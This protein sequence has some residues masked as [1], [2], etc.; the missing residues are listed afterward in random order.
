MSVHLNSQM[1]DPGLV[2]VT[3]GDRSCSQ[4]Y[5]LFVGMISSNV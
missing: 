5:F 4:P 2:R 3:G 1:K